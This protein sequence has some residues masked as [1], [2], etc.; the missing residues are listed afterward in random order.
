MNTLKEF[1]TI[2]SVDRKNFSL[3][4]CKKQTIE[5]ARVWAK[6]RFNTLNFVV[7]EDVDYPQL[8]NH[9]SF[10]GVDDPVLLEWSKVCLEIFNKL[11]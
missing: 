9:A 5:E 4:S 7:V 3:H 10:K 1:T 8:Y 11:F 6:Q 2:V